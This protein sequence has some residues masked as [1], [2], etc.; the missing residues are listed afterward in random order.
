M[1]HSYIGDKI[2]YLDDKLKKVNE[3]IV[4]QQKKIED[5]EKENMRVKY[6]LD[7]QMEIN[8]QFEGEQS[9]LRKELLDIEDNQL[10]N[11]YKM[12]IIIDIVKPGKFNNVYIFDIIKKF[13]Q[14]KYVDFNNKTNDYKTKYCSFIPKCSNIKNEIDKCSFAHSDEEYSYFNY[15]YD[16]Y[17]ETISNLG[18]NVPIKKQRKKKIEKKATISNII[19]IGELI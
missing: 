17:K 16:R 12:N 15:I 19:P 13:P 14:L 4:N 7:R 2:F 1:E 18:I 8:N 10:E 3:I 5:L 11:K 9:R 6:E